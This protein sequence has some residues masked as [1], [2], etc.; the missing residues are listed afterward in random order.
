M[1]ITIRSS[2][3]V[4]HWNNCLL[5]R[6]GF[7][8]NSFVF[9]RGVFQLHSELELPAY[10]LAMLGPL[11]ISI[12]AFVTESLNPD[13]FLKICFLD[14]SPAGC[15]DDGGN[16]CTRGSRITV[17]L[18]YSVGFLMMCASMVGFFGTY[19]VYNTVRK[20]IKSSANRSFQGAAT[21]S[22]S[23][24]LQEVSWQAV[25]YY[26]VY[27]NSFLWPMLLTILSILS[28]PDKKE[29]GSFNEIQP[30]S[31]LWLEYLCWT[32]FPL[33]GFLNF[34]VFSRPDLQ[35][36]R[37]LHTKRSILWAFRMVLFS[38]P[39]PLYH[40][41]S[42]LGISSRQRS[43]PCIFSVEQMSTMGSQSPTADSTNSVPYQT[44]KDV[45]TASKPTSENS[46]LFPVSFQP[47]LETPIPDVTSSFEEDSASESSSSTVCA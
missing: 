20:R 29:V 36:W 26:L 23:L 21:E 12:P 35:R 1:V 22:M 33:Q 8:C 25:L 17:Y 45:E 4:I 34:L 46:A 41:R 3:D 32:F 9:G 47:E 13:Q 14:G 44:D 39:P 7:A 37:K 28:S 2:D 27:F 40:G 5:Y 18:S 11:V 30:K 15:L 42:S 24:R 10:A 43:T 38:D 19:K 6:C 16:E 31:M